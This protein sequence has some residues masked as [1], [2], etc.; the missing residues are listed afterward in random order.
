M[1]QMEVLDTNPAV[2][3]SANRYEK[4]LRKAKDIL[5]KTFDTQLSDDDEGVRVEIG[6]I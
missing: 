4:A 5:N 1:L 3:S 6:S 2:N